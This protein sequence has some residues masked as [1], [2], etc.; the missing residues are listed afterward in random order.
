MF[1]GGLVLLG[2]LSA[3]LGAI[4]DLV[5]GCAA[6]V[7]YSLVCRF[8]LIL[9]TP[10]WHIW[11]LI[12]CTTNLAVHNRLFPELLNMLCTRAN[13]PIVVSSSDQRRG[14]YLIIRQLLRRSLTLSLYFELV[15][16]SVV[17]LGGLAKL[18]MHQTSRH[19]ALH[20]LNLTLAS[21]HHSTSCRLLLP[22]SF[23]WHHLTSQRS[24][25]SRSS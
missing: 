12:E 24:T 19:L 6:V 20:S 14:R 10:Q 4:E 25:M 13:H 18:S 3:D 2:A 9:A 17:D 23:S 8:E 7:L 16:H 1:H 5:E 11:V 21:Q 22:R 15:R